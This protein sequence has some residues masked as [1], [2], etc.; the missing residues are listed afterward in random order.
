[1]TKKIIT[2]IILSLFIGTFIF[3]VIYYLSN[4]QEN[5][6]IKV[7]SILKSTPTPTPQPT[8]PPITEN[9]NLNEEIKTLIPKDYSEEINGL[10][11]N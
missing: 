11:I 9:S 4:K 2:V 7:T 5:P 8:L 6:L 3:L 10:K 1:M